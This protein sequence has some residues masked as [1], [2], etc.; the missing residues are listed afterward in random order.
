F[1]WPEDLLIK[2]RPVF[3]CRALPRDQPVEVGRTDT[4]IVVRVG[5]W[6]VSCAIQRDVRFPAVE[7]VVPS[8]S[9]VG[10]RLRLDPAGARV[11]ESALGRLPGDQEFNSPVT[12]DLNGAVAVRAT[13]A[14]QP[15]RVTEL[16][17]NRS[18]Y[19]G[20]PLCLCTNRALL[21][22]A[23][24]LGFRELGFTGIDSPFVCRDTGRVYAVQPLSGGSPP[25]AGAE[26]IRIESGTATGS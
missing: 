25:A 21:E 26:V 15:N 13:S 22:R 16:V 18:S 1:P 17:L 19:T 3:A 10:T 5:P 4:H 8:A 9:E 23:L 12:V 7:R 2:A 14:D 20:P 24:R 6:I 11:L